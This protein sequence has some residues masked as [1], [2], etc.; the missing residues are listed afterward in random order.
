MEHIVVVVGQVADAAQGQAGR[1]KTTLRVNMWLKVGREEEE[2]MILGWK[3]GGMCRTLC[4]FKRKVQLLLEVRRV[5]GAN[6]VGRVSVV[7][8]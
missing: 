4:V 3:E 1:A 8:V 6:K 5:I 7:P 2:S